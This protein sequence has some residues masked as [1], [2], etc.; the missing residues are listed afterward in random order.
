MHHA[1]LGRLLG[2]A[3]AGV[4]L[5]VRKTVRGACDAAEVEQL[6]QGVTCD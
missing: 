2:V 6:P 1:L 3:V 4:L 5:P